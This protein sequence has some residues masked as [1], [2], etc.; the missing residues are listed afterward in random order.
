MLALQTF[1]RTS[2]EISTIKRYNNECRD[3]SDSEGYYVVS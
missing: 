3:I 1:F 2:F